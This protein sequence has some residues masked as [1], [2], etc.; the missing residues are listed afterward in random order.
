[1]K[2]FYFF[3]IS[4]IVCSD[5]HCEYRTKNK[6]D[7]VTHQKFKHDIGV[8]WFVCPHCDFRTKTNGNLTKHLQGVHHIGGKWYECPDCDYKTKRKK[9]F[10]NI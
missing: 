3:K 8:K 5:P 7:L 4:F 2:N 1:M 9:D 10:K 6:S